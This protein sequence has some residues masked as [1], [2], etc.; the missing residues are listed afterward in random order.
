MLSLN[1]AFIILYS[2]FISVVYGQ[3]E[4]TRDDETLIAAEKEMKA[5]KQLYIEK[6]KQLAIEETSQK[7]Q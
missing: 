4:I 3:Y 7:L 5:K 2:Y 6:K 1:L